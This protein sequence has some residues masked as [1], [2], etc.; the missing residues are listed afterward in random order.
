MTDDIDGPDFM[1]GLT[2]ESTGL[3]PLRRALKRVYG[4]HFVDLIE[5][6]E[7]AIAHKGIGSAGM[8]VRNIM[9]TLSDAASALAALPMGTQNEWICGLDDERRERQRAIRVWNTSP[10][11]TLTVRRGEADTVLAHGEKE[12]P[13]D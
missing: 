5:V 4:E 3:D 7:R 2:L 8:K 9:S 6:A 1:D 13:N 11:A 10:A 12:D